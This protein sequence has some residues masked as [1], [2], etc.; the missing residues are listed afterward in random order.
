MW[1]INRDNAEKCADEN[2]CPV[3]ENNKSPG[4]TQNFTVFAI[5]LGWV[6]HVKEVEIMTASGEQ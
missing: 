1:N 4:N 6:A 2:I 5:H 3:W